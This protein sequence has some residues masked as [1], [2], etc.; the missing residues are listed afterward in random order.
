LRA[1]IDRFGEAPCAFILGWRPSTAVDAHAVK[2][3]GKNLVW[4]DAGR[5]GWHLGFEIQ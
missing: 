5:L 3:F 2:W 4:A 1:R